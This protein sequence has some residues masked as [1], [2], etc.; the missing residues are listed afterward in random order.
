MVVAGGAVAT[1]SMGA[2]GGGGE[3]L[4]WSIFE[5]R[6]MRGVKVILKPLRDR[7]GSI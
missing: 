3:C 2:R 1:D 4:V 6:P 7:L 5:S